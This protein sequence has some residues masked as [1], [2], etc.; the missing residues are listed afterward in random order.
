MRMALTGRADV[1]PLR[2]DRMMLELR[3]INGHIIELELNGDAA[4]AFCLACLLALYG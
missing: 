3:T 1:R 4:R 2:G